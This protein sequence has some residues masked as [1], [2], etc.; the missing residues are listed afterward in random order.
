ML[1]RLHHTNCIQCGKPYGSPDFTYQAGRIENGPA[2]WSDRGLL[3]S[4]AC[5][6]AHTRQRL[7]A[8]DPMRDPA[9]NP[10]ERRR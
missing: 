4:A 2:Y 6:Q 3:C 7:A 8:G 5:G 10:L 9:E 1:N